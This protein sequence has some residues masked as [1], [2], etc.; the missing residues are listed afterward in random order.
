MEDHSQ[1]VAFAP[2]YGLHAVSDGYAASVSNAL[3]RGKQDHIAFAHRRDLTAAA[4][5]IFDE[6]L[7]T[8]KVAPTP[9]QHHEGLERE[10]YPAVDVSMRVVDAS[11]PI[12]DQD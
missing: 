8:G 7:A 10:P 12:A 2:G 9:R 6:E 1:G 11:F 4:R 5:F 3:S